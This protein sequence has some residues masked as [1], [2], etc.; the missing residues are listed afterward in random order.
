MS[1]RLAPSLLLLGVLMSAFGPSVSHASTTPAPPG[2]ASATAAAPSSNEPATEAELAALE[3]AIAALTLPAWQV[4]TTLRAS[5]GWRDNVL[6]S[7]VA[8]ESR[9]FARSEVEGLVW[10]PARGA[11]EHLAFLNGTLTRYA[12]PPP[13]VSGEQEWFLH[14]ET[15]W[16]PHPRFRLSASALGFYQ[17]QVLD[18]SATEA[19]RFVARIRLRGLLAGSE[20]RLRLPAGFTVAAFGQAQRADYRDFAEDYDEGRGGL[21][22]SWSRGET[23]TLSATALA[24]RR[25][26]AERVTYTASGRP[27]AG[28]RLH[29]SQKEGELKA[30]GRRGPWSVTGTARREESRDEASGFFDT[31]EEGF[32]IDAGWESDPWRVS[33]DAGYERTRY[34]V[35]TVGIGFEP[36]LRQQRDHEA[37]LRIERTLGEHWTLYGDAHWER[38]RTNLENASYTAKTFVL[39]VAWSR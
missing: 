35:Q 38:S 20:A 3:A 14:G 13:D 18:L 26:Y 10:R 21:R 17:D 37:R 11:W 1:L 8:P 25:S 12:D 34:P 36:E 23:V 2:P 19:E 39:G 5:A 6:L 29:F 27:L 4:D 7:A 9:A 22:A 16:Q 33:L 15:R 31:T 32:R 28:T 24:R 30:E